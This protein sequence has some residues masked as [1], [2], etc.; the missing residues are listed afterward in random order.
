MQFPT[1]GLMLVEMFVAGAAPGA[2]VPVGRE[3]LPLRA[4]GHWHSCQGRGAHPCRGLGLG[5]HL[6]TGAVLALAGQGMVAPEALR[7][8]E[9]Y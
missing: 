2:H 5:W 8:E 1:K 3:F 7:I 4:G 9:N 6:G